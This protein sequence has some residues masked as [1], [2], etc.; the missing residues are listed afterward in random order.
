MAST[1]TVNALLKRLDA[2]RD[3]YQ[4]TFSLIHEVLAQN[5]AA[6]VPSGAPVP[7]TQTSEVPPTPRSPRQS[8]SGTTAE[9]SKKHRKFS[10]GL[11]TLT[12]SS[13]SKHTGNSDSEADDEELYASHFL[14]PE[15]YDEEGLR[16]HLPKIKYYEHTS[17]VLQTVIDNPKR[18]LQKP[19]IPHRK[20]QLEDR[21]HFSHYQVF[22]VGT[23]G[24]LLQVERTDIEQ[25]ASRA[26]AI[27]HAI[28][29]LNQPPKERLAV[30]R[31]TILRE[32]SPILFGAAH[33]A[34][35]KHFDVDELFRHLVAVDGSSANF[36]RAFDSD[37]RKQ[38]SFVFNFEYYTI[39][40]QDCEPMRWQ[41]SDLQNKRSA[42]HIP[43][44]RCSSV[45]ALVLNGPAVRKVRNPSR[46]AVNSH[47]F[48]YDPWSSW[49]VLNL[50]C[51]PDWNASTEVH[52]STRHYVNGV[53]AFMVTV[54]GEFR[55]AQ[56]RFE[57]IYRAITK[58][59]TPPLDFM[60][61]ADIRD[62]L[63][64][65]DGDLT[66]SRRY[67]W[68]STTLALV[69][70]SI[71]NMLEA[72]EDNF[73]DDVWEGTHKTLW[74]LLEYDSA[75]NV[76]FRK[77]MALLRTRFEQE[78]EN[79]K[80]QMQE[81]DDRR[82]EI[83]NLKEEL[84]KGTS[85]LES[86]KSVENTEITIQQGNNIKLLTL[87]NIFFLP[88]TF[89]SSVFGMTNM[90][91]TEHY[92]PFAVVTVAICVPFF[93]L[94]G[95]LNTKEG[96]HWW[97][98]KTRDLF[99]WIGLTL[100]WL[101]RKHSEENDNLSRTSSIDEMYG[102]RR[103]SASRSTSQQKARDLPLRKITT[104]Q[105]F[106]ISRQSIDVRNVD[107]ELTREGNGVMRAPPARSQSS[108]LAVMWAE[109]REGKRRRT[110]Q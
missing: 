48:A 9:R 40:G 32:L 4:E 68:A 110:V 95:S 38:R 18:M 87:V 30:G 96:M 35:S 64:F 33:F 44:T 45:V 90:P 93:V 84:F 34:F 13:D 21:S 28:R 100:K 63:L 5:L 41:T 102:L 2:Q 27:W 99:Q 108:N 70:E 71:R 17:K 6:I 46:R 39:V 55:D 47:G 20:G 36:H 59:I 77:R 72:Y 103:L 1:E 94:V 105:K 58:L 106:E 104:T 109:E 53:E 92:W 23:D 3:A 31:I 73:T 14:E 43:I 24:A 51:Y 74:P 76:Y 101:F 29:E 88:L 89:S 56:K 66:Y 11:A 80:K 98:S 8:V 22:D 57:L 62:E 82:D 26:Q 25:E 50:Q 60:F 12:T 52:D 78:I 61:D 97:R 7:A 91:T 49:Q 19:L 67:F 81:N 65:E 10:G 69:N 79:L 37:E 42:H 85:I 16:T 107:H 15:I 54:L 86:R 83:H 75:R